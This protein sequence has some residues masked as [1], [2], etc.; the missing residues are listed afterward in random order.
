VQAII[1]AELSEGLSQTYPS[2]LRNLLTLAKVDILMR[3]VDANCTWPHP[4][5]DLARVCGTIETMLASLRQSALE[6]AQASDTNPDGDAGNGQPGAENQNK[7]FARMW[8]AVVAQCDIM[9][10]EVMRVSLCMYVCIFV[11]MH[12]GCGI[13]AAGQCMCLYACIHTGCDVLIAE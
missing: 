5:E 1:S 10:A 4:N 13:S 7:P 2:A 8:L 6:A 3:L 11:Y 12:M 9:T